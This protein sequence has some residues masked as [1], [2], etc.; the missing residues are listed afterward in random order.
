M[1]THK[2]LWRLKRRI[3]GP[4]CHSYF[5]KRSLPLSPWHM[6]CSKR[7]CFFVS[8]TWEKNSHRL[9]CIHLTSTTM[10]NEHCFRK[11]LCFFSNK[12]NWCFSW[13][14]L[15][16]SQNWNNYFERYVF[17]WMSNLLQCLQM[18]IKMYY[19]IHKAN[20]IQGTLWIIMID[21]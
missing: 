3:G 17:F 5:N 15:S 20:K 10:W 6:S 18:P 12:R 16:V 4:R 1:N 19:N 7:S 11:N 14:Y 9:S 21:S 8:A 13:G 2:L